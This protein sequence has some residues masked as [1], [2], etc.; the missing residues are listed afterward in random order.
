MFPK[1]AISLL[2][3]CQ[4]H[5]LAPRANVADG[6][7]RRNVLRDLLMGGIAA[8][9]AP[10]A[11]QAMD[12]L[13]VDS[14]LKS[15]GVSMPMGVS[16]QGG[17]MRPETGVVLR[18]GAEL[19]R[20]SRNGNVAAEIVL[21]ANKD[22]FVPVLATFS[23]PWPLASGST[24]DVECRDGNTGDGV[25]LAVSSN[26][27]GKSILQLD[28]QFFQ[29]Q[30]FSP[31]GRFSFYGAPTDV[32]IKKSKAPSDDDAYKTMDIDFSILSQSTGAEVPRKARVVATIPPGSSQVV[33]LVAS[34]SAGRWRK[35]SDEKI[36]GIIDSFRAVLAPQ[37][38]LRLKSRS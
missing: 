32:K 6:S 25:Y 11:A 28:N 34:A 31:T 12:S 27:K 37:T 38:N 26:V 19:S 13:D 18:D 29:E 35:G 4:C 24:Y 16:G 20:D 10:A 36:A 5:A 7:T 9:T 3:F 8:T 14:Y 22:E 23:S 15:G 30:L 17:K 2:L 1:A 33:M 21:Q